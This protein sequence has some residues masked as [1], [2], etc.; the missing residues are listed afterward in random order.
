VTHPVYG[1]EDFRKATDVSR[2]TLDRLVAYADLLKRWQGTINLIGRSSLDELW[3]R[4][5][6]DSA[7]LL[8]LA[9]NARCWLDLGSGAGFPGLVLAILGAPEVHLVESN[10]RKCA[11][12]REAARIAGAEVTVHRAR[13]ETLTPWPA[14]A[15]VARGLAP[16]RR[17][18]EL[19]APFCETDSV[20]LFPKGQDVENELTEATKY[21]NMKVE[22]L[23]SVSDP[24]GTILRLTEVS[25]V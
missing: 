22:R 2:E 8:P 10:A 9:P 24:A 19:G 15:V 17:L 3:R 21:W 1:P 12:L 7:Q 14:D 13:I 25:R 5:M 16:L 6:L 23:P 4:H 20:C 11:F 18:L